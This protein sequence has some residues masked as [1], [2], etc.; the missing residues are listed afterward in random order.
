MFIDFLEMLSK[1]LKDVL[2]GECDLPHNSLEIIL[3]LSNKL[4]NLTQQL[5]VTP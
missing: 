4:L 2:A 1:F 3:E 5:Y